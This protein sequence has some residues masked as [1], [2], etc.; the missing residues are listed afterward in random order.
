M[1][2]GVILFFDK[3]LSKNLIKYLNMKSLRKRLCDDSILIIT[4]R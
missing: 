4:L 1:E 3:Y 2:I